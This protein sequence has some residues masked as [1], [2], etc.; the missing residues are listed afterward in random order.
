[1]SVADHQIVLFHGSPTDA[2][3][4]ILAEG[5]RAP[6]Y[7]WTSEDLAREFLGDFLP[8]GWLLWKVGADGLVLRPDPE[9]DAFDGEQAALICDS[10]IAVERLDLHDSFYGDGDDDEDWDDFDRAFA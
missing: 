10:P 4:S 9:F 7:L 6:V 1:M 8:Q 5:L 3:T 2:E